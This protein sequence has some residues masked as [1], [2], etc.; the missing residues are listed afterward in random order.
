MTY[1]LLGLAI[2]FG[3]HLFSAVRSRSVERDIK[4]RLGE[5]AYM[6]LYSLVSAIGFGLIIYGF[7][8]ARPSAVIYTPPSWGRHI[9]MALML[10]AMIALVS[11]Y[12]PTG[13]IKKMLRHPM[14][15]SVKLW[16]LAHL[17]A[18]GDVA[19]LLLF[20]SF[21]AYAVIDR[22]AVKRRGDVG[23]PPEAGIN[24]SGDLL[25]V[26]I[27]AGLYAALLFWLHPILFG[28]AVIAT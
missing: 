22:I 28:A 18:N 24:P 14:L 27:G 5:G 1:L 16:A 7:V 11:S 3:A 20:G 21:L 19:S 15:V 4:V 23:V 12:L 2:F 8:A 26:V 10:P 13:R 6:G 25:A 17:L 9:A